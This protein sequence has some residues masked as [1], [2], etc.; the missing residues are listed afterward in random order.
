MEA[1]QQ[2]SGQGE[3]HSGQARQSTTSAA[4]GAGLHS[5]TPKSRLEGA[6]ER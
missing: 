6:S 3:L 5:H 2:E 4:S 1:E